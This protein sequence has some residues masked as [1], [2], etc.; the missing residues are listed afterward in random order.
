MTFCNFFFL[1]WRVVSLHPLPN[2]E[3]YPLSAVRNCSFRM[4]ADT[5]RMF[6]PSPSAACTCATPFWRGTHLTWKGKPHSFM[7][8]GRR[9]QIL[10]HQ[11]WKMR[12]NR[13][14]YYPAHSV[15]F[16]HWVKEDMTISYFLRDAV[17]RLCLHCQHI[18]CRQKWL[19]IQTAWDRYLTAVC[20]G[21]L[22]LP[23]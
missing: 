15:N 22:N 3:D 1:L 20:S 13:Q 8:S 9:N 17:K 18:S 12:T 14:T 5:L 6:R 11:I 10:F 2:L 23:E 16:I 19:L 7:K 21:S 4:F